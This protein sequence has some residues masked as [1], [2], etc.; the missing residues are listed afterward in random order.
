LRT[1]SATSIVIPTDAKGLFVIAWIELSQNA[2]L[3]EQSA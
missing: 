1:P 3:S 2:L